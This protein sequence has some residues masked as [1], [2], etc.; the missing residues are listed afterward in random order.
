MECKRDVYATGAASNRR[1]KNPSR[2]RMY[3]VD[4]RLRA[5][6]LSLSLASR[7][8]FL[9][10]DLRRP[11]RCIMTARSVGAALWRPHDQ[12]DRRPLD[13]VRCDKLGSCVITGTSVLGSARLV[14]V[15]RRIVAAANRRTA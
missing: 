3:T 15:F 1:R 9:E 6:S 13:A 10:T 4:A 7:A 12:P 5:L 14:P 8:A 11:R 2:R